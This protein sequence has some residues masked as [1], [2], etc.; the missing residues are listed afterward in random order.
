MKGRAR[1]HT[2]RRLVDIPLFW[3]GLGLSVLILFVAANAHLIVVAVQSQP[4]CVDHKKWSDDAPSEFHAAKSSC[5]S[6]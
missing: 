2:K 5:S 3:L 1:P 6:R 4:E